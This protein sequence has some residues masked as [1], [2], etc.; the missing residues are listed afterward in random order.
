[1]NRYE[2]LH[3]Y[4]RPEYPYRQ[5]KFYIPGS[6]GCTFGVA[7]INND[8]VLQ[9]NQSGSYGFVHYENIHGSHIDWQGTQEIKWK[10]ETIGKV[11]EQHPGGSFFSMM[12][13]GQDPNLK[14]S[15]DLSQKY[16]GA[17]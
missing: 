6:G 10:G 7:E 1:M 11:I 12:N 8:A 9:S 4:V 17:E 2:Y 13:G 16:P 3:N 5:V 14:I 15:S